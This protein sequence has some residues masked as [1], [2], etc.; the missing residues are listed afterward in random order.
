MFCRTCSRGGLFVGLMKIEVF[1]SEAMSDVTNSLHGAYG[2]FYAEAKV[3]FM[4]AVQR[5]SA[6]VSC[7][8]YSEGG[9]E[10][11]HR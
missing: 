9:P 3:N 8:I 5:H 6:A 10:H 2:F 11:R 7:S 1:D 4:S